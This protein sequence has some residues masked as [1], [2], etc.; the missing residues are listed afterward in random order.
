M[1]L[2]TVCFKHFVQAMPL[3]KLL[4]EQFLVDAYASPII[5]PP[6]GCKLIAVNNV[7]QLLGEGQAEEIACSQGQGVTG[8]AWPFEQRLLSQSLQSIFFK[9]QPEARVWG[10]SAGEHSSASQLREP[11]FLEETAHP[12]ARPLA[13]RMTFL[14]VSHPRRWCVLPSCKHESVSWPAAPLANS[15]A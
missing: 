2:H 7:P 15:A 8:G 13:C 4:L 3:Q 6:N 1:K 12:E 11:L 5:A 10:G 14:V 9:Q